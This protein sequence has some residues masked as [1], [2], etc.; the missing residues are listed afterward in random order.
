MS[1]LAYPYTEPYKLPA[2][3]L[4][5]LVHGAFFALLY[6]GVNWRTEPPQGMVVDIW[7][8]L[9][10]APSEPVVVAPPPAAAAVPSKPVE[11][12]RPVEPPKVEIALPDKKKMK[13]PEPKPEA[14]IKKPLLP[15][16]QAPPKISEAD[17]AQQAALA[18]QV[19]ARAAQAAAAA[20]AITSE[21]GK[22]TGLIRAKIKRNIVRPED[23]LDVMQADF[24]VVLLPGGSVLSVKRAKPSG[25][26]A[27]DEAVERAIMKSQPLPLPPD[28]AMFKYF[29]ELHLV[30][31]P[32]E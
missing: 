13:A 17:K 24:D 22:Y 5:L 21:V 28:V 6:F 32:K 3:V 12:P 10:V 1:A 26:T 4:A 16:K 18:E 19:R 31:T 27:Y 20:A 29:R 14:E 8:S 23:A 30:F 2:G 15:L 25:S 7:E 11:E 9:P